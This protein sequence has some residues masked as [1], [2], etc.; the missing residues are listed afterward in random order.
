MPD[1]DYILFSEHLILRYQLV[2]R[3]SLST[4]VISRNGR[5][6]SSHFIIFTHSQ[7]TDPDLMSCTTQML[8]EQRKKKPFDSRHQF[9]GNLFYTAIPSANF[10]VYH[11]SGNRARRTATMSETTVMDLTM[12][13]RMALS[14]LKAELRLVQWDVFE[15]IHSLIESRNQWWLPF[16]MNDIFMSVEE[17]ASPLSVSLS[18]GCTKWQSYHCSALPNLVSRSQCGNPAAPD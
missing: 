10:Q 1:F 9:L 2:S 11:S 7:V 16:T 4:Y 17:K 8:T 6:S 13:L 18:A 5:W 15:P 12:A 14:W 3:T